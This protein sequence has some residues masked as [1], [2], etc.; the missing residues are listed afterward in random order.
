[1][2]QTFGTKSYVDQSGETQLT[3]MC[4]EGSPVGV[5]SGSA[6]HHPGFSLLGASQVGGLESAKTDCELFPTY[7]VLSLDLL[8]KSTFT[9]SL[10]PAF[11]IRSVNQ[12]IYLIEEVKHVKNALIDKAP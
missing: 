11:E 1:M 4:Q 8:C 9:S 3:S 12:T 10:L 6:L 2:A 5:P 7:R